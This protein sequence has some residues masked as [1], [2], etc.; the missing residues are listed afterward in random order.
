MMKRTVSIFILLVA[1]AAS[2]IKN[3][4]PYPVIVPHI[5]ALEAIGASSVSCN[6]DARTVKIKL[7]EATDITCVKITSVTI[8]EKNA[9]SSL[10]IVGVH[11]LSSP[12]EVVLSIYQDYAWTISATQE[13]ERY[14]TVAGQVGA[15]VFDI[16]NRRV[17]VY[18]SKSSD[19]ENLKVLSMKLGPADITTYSVDRHSMK[20]FTNGISVDVSAWGRTEEWHLFAE[21]TDASVS[22]DNVNPWTRECYVS[23]TGVAGET[24]IFRF[25]KSGTL[26]WTDVDDSDVTSSGGSFLAHLTELEPETD[27]ECY[28]LNGSDETEVVEFTTD[29]AR[30]IPNG[31]LETVSKVTGKD[32]YKWFDPSSPDPECRKIWW[33][34][35]NGEGDDGYKGTASLGIVLT[36]PDIDCHEGKLSAR[37]QSSQ[38]AGILACGNLFTGQFTQII[39]SSAGAV[40]Y[41]RPWT[42]RPRAITLWYK[43]KG[44]LVDCV[45]EYPSDDVVRIGDKDRFQIF[46]SVGD[47]DYRKYGGDPDSPVRVST[48]HDERSTLFTPESAGIIACG[49]VVSNKDVSEWT[50]LEIPLEYRSLD[51]KPTHIIIICAV[52]YRGDYMSGCSTARLWLDDFQVVY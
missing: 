42:T 40:H 30:Q 52:N 5:T 46:V 29:P 27:Y 33:A 14:F 1:A 28:V 45:D 10:D 47:W 37:A 22:V 24:T 2:C 43:Y 19:L 11:D 23:A 31:G 6:M 17:V 26:P 18:V 15:T 34:S 32:Y 25:R 38:L 8:D 13:I 35:G 21:V 20:D 9:K 3:D 48:A 12:V 16:P 36:E 50:K 44:G 51:R 39:G 4:I 7:E 49:N 41:G